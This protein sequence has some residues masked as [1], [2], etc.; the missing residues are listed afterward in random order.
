MRKFIKQIAVYVAVAFLASEILARIFIDPVYFQLVDTYNLNDKSAPKFERITQAFSNQKTSKVDYLFIGSSRVPASI[1]PQVFME[2]DS[3]KVAVVAGRG[4]MTAGIH[5]QALK[6]RLKDFPD[7]LKGATVFLEYPGSRIYDQSFEEQVFKV[8]E[9]GSEA[10]P[11]LL[12]P[13]L[14]FVDLKGFLTQSPNSFGVKAEMVGLYLS[15]FYRSIPFI[16]ENLTNLEKPLFKQESDKSGILASDGGIRNDNLDFAKAK[17]IELAET[18][19]NDLA[20]SPQISP[21]QLDKSILVKI[22]ELI[23]SNQGK[24]VLYKMPLHSIQQEI[25]NSKQEIANKEIFESW[26]TSNEI[27]TLQNPNF[28]YEDSDFPDVW[29]LSKARRDEFSKLLFEELERK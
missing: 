25:Y 5:Y 21:S 29:H 3:G 6:M 7:F 11:H 23:I 24:L 17:A 20:S 13:H 8:H 12:I 18:R 16:R 22:H 9:S 27:Q 15:A 26:L 28:E 10:M 19:K 1:N 14:D 2:L 4:F